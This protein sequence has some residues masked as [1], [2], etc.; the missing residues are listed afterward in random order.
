MKRT[1]PDDWHIGTAVREVRK[2]ERVASRR[3]L[4][5]GAVAQVA[6]EESDA[7]DLERDDVDYRDVESG[8]DS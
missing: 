8:A 2:A 3:R 4:N 6:Q 1:R 5:D 7:M